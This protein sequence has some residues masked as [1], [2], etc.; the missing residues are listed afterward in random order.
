MNDN[1]ERAIEDY[2]KRIEQLL[3][4]GFETEDLIEDLREHILQSYKSKMVERPS[5]KPVVLVDEVL[6]ELGAPEDIAE[7]QSQSRQNEVELDEKRSRGMYFLGR[8]ALALIVVV[9]AA[10]F[11]AFYTDGEMDFGFTLAVLLVFVIAEWFVR[12][13]QAGE[14]S[15]FG[16]LEKD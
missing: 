2:L 6:E 11:V 4:S 9:I 1:A 8:L 16:F 3:P 12:A 5:E 7:E 10:A 15:P 13:W 14:A